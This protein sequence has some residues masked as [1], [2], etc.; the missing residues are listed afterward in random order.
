MRFREW[1]IYTLPVI[2]LVKLLPLLAAYPLRTP[3]IESVLPVLFAG[4]VAAPDDTD[5]DV[6]S[7]LREILLRMWFFAF[8]VVGGASGGP[9]R[10]LYESLP[11]LLR[12]VSLLL[13][14]GASPNSAEPSCDWL[15]F[16]TRRGLVSSGAAPKI[17]LLPP[18]GGFN[19]LKQWNNANIR[20]IDFK[21]AWWKYNTSKI[22]HWSS[23]LKH[24]STSKINQSIK[25]MTR[26]RGLKSS[27]FE[28]T[29][30]C[31]EYS[32]KFLGDG[33][34]FLTVFRN[35]CSFYRFSYY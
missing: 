15:W 10:R 7:P 12:G 19:T 31:T 25:F 33:R 8:G 32:Q 28:L 4:D 1:R 29:I 18:P 24:Q 5:E 14:F 2:S 26:K 11:G 6:D 35:K 23:I 16:F 30:S 21:D 27:S 9:N 3:A 22:C 20:F 13:L 34:L 17:S